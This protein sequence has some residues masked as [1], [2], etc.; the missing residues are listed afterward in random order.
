MATS[1]MKA[2]WWPQ[3]DQTPVVPSRVDACYE[4]YDG[5]SS[6]PRFPLDVQLLQEQSVPLVHVLR[7]GSTVARRPASASDLRRGQWDGLRVTGIV[8]R[9]RES[10]EI[11]K[12]AVSEITDRIWEQ[13]Q[14]FCAR[15]LS[16]IEVEYL[17]VDAVFESLRRHGAKEAV[18]VAWGIDSGGFKHL[19]HLAVGNK[20]SE[21]A[22]TEFFRHM[23]ARG[24]RAPTSVTADGAPGLTNA[25][26]SV[27]PDSIR[28][29]CWFHRLSNIRAKLPDDAAPEVMAHVR[30]IRDAATLDQARA[31][32]DQVINRFARTFP[33]AMDCLA[34]DLDALLAIHRIPHRHRIN[35]RTTNLAER[36]FVEER[37]T[38]IIPRFTD[39][40]SA[41]KL[42]FATLIRCADRW[43]RVSVSEVERHQLHLLR[44]ELGIDP[45]PSSD[46]ST[47]TKKKTAA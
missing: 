24:L 11:S 13:F 10:G 27:W 17:F 35:V 34:D 15:D 44:V 46:T 36:S 4:H 38:K 23:V 6:L 12:S 18:L 41:M 37:R 7:S 21:Q 32:A 31:T 43:S 14:A 20:G 16:D 39:E 26:G 1:S 9:V 45:P 42:V 33:A 8:R 40:R 2:P 5:N 19:L 47:I 29:R 25:I 30:T 28:I 22:R 3:P